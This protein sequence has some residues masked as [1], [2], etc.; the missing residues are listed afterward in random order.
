MA[1]RTAKRLEKL[2]TGIRGL[3]EALKGGI[4]K[5][6]A[7]LVTGATGTGKTVFLNEFLYRG[8]TQ[9]GENGV[10]VTFE[11]TSEDITRNVLGF[12]WNYPELVR[13]KKLI[14]EDVS[15]TEEL[16]EELGTDYELT[17]L[18][19]RIKYAAKLIRAKRVAVDMLGGLFSRLKNEGR[20][21]EA[22]CR[23]SVELKRLG[24]TTMISSE[25]VREEDPVSRFGVEE[26]VADAVIELSLKPG[27]HKMIRSLLI[28]KVRGVGYRSG[29]IE[30]EITDRGLEVFPKIPFN[31]LI[32]KTSFAVR[33]KCGIP[34]LDRALGGGIPQGHML[35]VTGNTGTG[36][37]LFGMRW[38]MEG[39]RRGERGVFVALEEPVPQ[40]KKTA[41]AH[42]WD[43][44]RLERQGKLALF[45]PGLIDVASDRL[46]YEIVHQVERVNAK[47]VVFDSI[48]S[49]MSAS[50][51]LEDTEGVRQFLIQLA[52]FLRSRG[53]TAVFS[54]LSGTNF[55]AVKGQLLS[56]F[57]TNEM[58]LSSVVDGVILLLYV[59]R[60]QKVAKLLN[61]LKLRGSRH[62]K[63]I[64]E[65]EIKKGGFEIQGRF[66]Q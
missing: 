29:R 63:D 34:A 57:N 36:K 64:L 61:V 35:M 5:G 10:F 51:N 45:R 47:R 58:R 7:I 22:L 21:R 42:G 62:V 55:G 38:L 19:E 20:I 41:L 31:P 26:F 39:V 40:V 48:S 44:Q 30:Y 33:K 50:V 1:T 8:I 43:F 52:G 37:S 11:E 49:L 23:L 9:F 65:Y 27:Q 59:E 28:R 14:F 46:L 32:A 56:A 15:P 17:P 53:V 24:L 66:S 4:P 3:D 12:G 13:R 2:P 54:Y 18:I 25:R 16:H 6:R 60:G